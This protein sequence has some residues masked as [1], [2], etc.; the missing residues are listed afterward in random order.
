MFSENGGQANLI[1][2]DLAQLSKITAVANG[3]VNVM[4][5]GFL[6]AENQ[7]TGKRQAEDIGKTTKR[8]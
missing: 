3:I 8:P 4:N 6:A 2:I 1:K 5:I 7:Y